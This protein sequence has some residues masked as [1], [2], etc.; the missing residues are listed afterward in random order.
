MYT[1]ISGKEFYAEN[2]HKTS[3]IFHFQIKQYDITW[4]N[5]WY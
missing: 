2:R 4:P 3:N 1:V 5:N